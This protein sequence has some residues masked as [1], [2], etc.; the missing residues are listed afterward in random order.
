MRA[1]L[2]DALAPA[3]EHERTE[4]LALMKTEDFREGIA[5]SLERRRPEFS[6]R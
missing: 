2:V 6:G 5:A 4:Q 3:I 1:G